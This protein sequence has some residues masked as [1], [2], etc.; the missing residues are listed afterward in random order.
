MAKLSAGKRK[1]L[2]DSAFAYVDPKG[3]RRLP[4]HDESHV[5]NALSRF[6]QVVFEDDGARNRARTRLLN[7]AKRYGLMPVGFV[8]GQLLSHGRRDLPT[9]AVTFLM[10]DIEESTALMLQLEERYSKVLADARRVSRAAVRRAGG[11]E[12]DARADEYF[13]VF[14]HAPQAIE[15][16]IDIQRHFRDHPWPDGVAVRARMGIHGGRPTMSEGG[17]VGVS[18]H[19]VARIT[20]LA[21]GGQIIVSRAVLPVELP[22]EIV[23]VELGEHH[24]RGLGGHSLF[25]VS[26]AD[27]RSEFSALATG[28]LIP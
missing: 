26:V 25:Q 12:V 6:N 16:A 3:R 7:A 21:H 20:A 2:R 28:R 11:W 22:A 24:L 17:Y 5:R 4:I 8:T 19:T 27:L 23:V 13:A 14:S 18:V 10:T 1:G 9:G 15:A